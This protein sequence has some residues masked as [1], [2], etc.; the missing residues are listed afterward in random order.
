MIA[1]L[2][3]PVGAI[4]G[5]IFGIYVGTLIV[6][7]GVSNCID[8]QVLVRDNRI[9]QSDIAKDISDVNGLIDRFISPGLVVPSYQELSTVEDLILATGYRNPRSVRDVPR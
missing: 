1:V 3:A 5:E 7:L 4:S 9:S 2:I 8:L 6:V